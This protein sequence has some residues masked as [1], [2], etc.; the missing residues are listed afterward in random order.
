MA[1]V[2]REDTL[3]PE[4]I[5]VDVGRCHVERSDSEVETSQEIPRQ[6][7]DDKK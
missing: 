6:A 2:V 4:P 1:E 3:I 5:G 7:R